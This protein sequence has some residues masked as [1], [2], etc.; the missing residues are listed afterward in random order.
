MYRF[1]IIVIII[2][3]IIIVM[4]SIGIIGIIKSINVIICI[5]IIYVCSPIGIQIQ[6]FGARLIPEED[7]VNLDQVPLN[8]DH[9]SKTTY[10]TQDD[11]RESNIGIAS[12]GDGS[13]K[14]LF[15][16]S[17]IEIDSG[18]HK[19]LLFDIIF[20]CFGVCSFTIFK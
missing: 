4:I 8:C 10:V 6:V 3:V 12:G 20:I 1:I 7:R 9:Q 5:I 13:D 14:R 19:I 18:S 15:L 2:A 16:R 11:A 17:S